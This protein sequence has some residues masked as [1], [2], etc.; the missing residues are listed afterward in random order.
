MASSATG[1]VISPAE[2]LLGC[3][4]VEVP[5]GGDAR[6]GGAA[7]AATTFRG[8]EPLEVSPK[9]TSSSCEESDSSSEGTAC[10][11]SSDCDSA[12]G[13][14]GDARWSGN[15]SVQASAFNAQAS[16][17][18]LGD[19]PSFAVQQQGGSG[20]ASK[21]IPIMKGIIGFKPIVYRCFPHN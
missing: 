19:G 1:G 2:Q 8:L 9:Q 20:G 7:A 14:L 5:G 18:F 10:D 6:V 15:V 21:N 4:A 11:S 12:E 16:P 13:V 3:D 17:F